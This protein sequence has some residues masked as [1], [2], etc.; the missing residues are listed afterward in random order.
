MEATALLSA[1]FRFHTLLMNKKLLILEPPNRLLQLEDMDCQT[2][3]L[4]TA[5]GFTEALCL[6][7]VKQKGFKMI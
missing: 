2:A 1:I 7:K 4:N 5:T 6:E 3:V